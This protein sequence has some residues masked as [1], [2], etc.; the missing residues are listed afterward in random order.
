MDEGFALSRRQLLDTARTLAVGG[1]AGL[2]IPEALA[3]APRPARPRV[4]GRIRVAYMSISTADTLDPARAGMS[5]DYARH[6]LLYSRLFDLSPAMQ[7]VPALAESFAT[8]DLK[9]WRLTL[10]KSV[11]FHDGKSVTPADVVYSLLR[12]KEPATGSK[13]AAVA[14]QFAS[15]RADGP[16]AVVIDL[17]GPNAD[18]PIILAQ[19]H[20]SILPAGRGRV[21]GVGCGPFKLKTFSPGVRTVVTRNP[22]F[23]R[24]GRPYLEEIEMIGVPDEVS[25]INA[26]LSGDVQMAMGVNP[27]S[28]RRVLES[29]GHVMH[30]APSGMY[31]NLAMRQDRF[32]AANPHFGL[33]IKY[34]MDRPLIKRALFRN[35][36][37]IGNDHPIPPFHPFYRAD[38]PQ[39]GLDLDRAK[40]HLQKSGVGITRVPMFASAAAEAS[41]DMASILQE[42]AAKV[43]LN[44]AV[45]RVPADGYWSTHWMRHPLF[46]GNNNPRPTADLLFSLFYK[47]DAAWNESGWKNARFDSLLVEA[48]GERDFA[49]R[50]QLYGE[51]Q[52]LARAYCSVSIP[53]FISLLDGWDRRL[54]GWFSHPLGNF[55]G[56]TFGEHMWWEG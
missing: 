31:T 43:G 34:L 23:W 35:Y 45:N 42:Y 17:V 7:P 14:E 48:R 56:H 26:L 8:E 18:L 15:V 55:M 44:L 5:T 12:H 1:A 24:P 51:M 46:F 2:L 37:T 6:F 47:S 41:V 3:A 30:A 32:P 49:R 22:N 10:R 20:F 50:K 39:T 25:R 38:L 36:A 9:R 11:V 13:L 40:W 27:R 54:K 33:G 52:G 4:G 21:T 16:N 29:P 53:V 19:T 28:A